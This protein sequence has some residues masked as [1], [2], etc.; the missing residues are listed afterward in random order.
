M[1]IETYI[2]IIN[3]KEIGVVK[4]VFTVAEGLC[5]ALNAIVVITDLNVHKL[6]NWYK[7][8]IRDYE[9]SKWIVGISSSAISFFLTII[10]SVIAILNGGSL[11]IGWIELITC[12]LTTGTHFVVEFK[13][14]YS[15]EKEK[16]T[17][18]SYN[19]VFAVSAIIV[20]NDKKR[21]LLVTRK[22]NE[23]TS[24]NMWV[25]PGVYYRTNTLHKDPPDLKTFHEHLI[26]SIEAECGLTTGQYKPMQLN[27]MVVNMENTFTGDDL[28][29]LAV[30]HYKNMLAQTPFLIQVENSISMKSSNTTRH[31][32]C[33]YAFEL[34]IND[35]QTILDQIRRRSTSSEA[36]Y[37]K[38]NT[39][40]YDEVLDMCKP[41][42]LHRDCSINRCYPDLA[43]I[44]RNFFELWRKELF[45][46][47]FSNN[48]RYC[49]FNPNKH[50]IWIRLNNN[51]NLSCEFC[52]M[53]NK[54]QKTSCTSCNLTAFQ[55]FWN[56]LDAFKEQSKYHLV[57]TGGEPFLVKELYEMI[58]HMEKNSEGKI[59]SITICTNGTLG[60]VDAP[61]NYKHHAK[62]NLDKLLDDQCPFKDKLKFVV[63]MSS[64]DEKSFNRITHG[65]KS[66]YNQQRQFISALQNHNIQNITAN[67]VM[68]DILKNNLL[69]YFN[70]WKNM[71]IRNIAFSYA[72]QL[73]INSRNQINSTNS[74]SKA[75]CLSLYNSIGNGLYPIECFENIELMIPSCDEKASCK[76][77]KNIL[78]CYQE[79]P[80]CWKSKFGCMDI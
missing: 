41:E 13:K 75:E 29:E 35:D 45:L 70:E 33:F 78:S 8:H 69:T 6:F 24:E 58:S 43:I 38:I 32:D 65:K 67:I 52:L 36:K 74:L 31:I 21:V 72:I 25:Q 59:T 62:I 26:A 9:L 10:L 40:T 54:S 44:L 11:Y 22:Q 80:D 56:A 61:R 4:M 66:L 46:S 14:F 73:G 23:N 27:S 42:G 37:G 60:V 50:T 71:G 20:T 30:S 19:G 49:T 3:S 48:I 15:H 39:F 53:V 68:T 1:C 51:C 79:T 55:S 7:D 77:N 16:Q 18:K 28:T 34:S 63:N 64:H 47:K 2:Y 57:I 17:Y 12:A 5:T 76:E